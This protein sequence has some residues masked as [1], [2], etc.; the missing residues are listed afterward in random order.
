MPPFGPGTSCSMDVKRC[1]SGPFL[2]TAG[3]TPSLSR[4]DAEGGPENGGGR[5]PEW[6]WAG[7]REIVWAGGNE[8][9]GGPRS[10]GRIRNGGGVKPE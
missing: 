10:G 1:S 3:M 5:K 6:H 8:D 2:K 4:N 9:E 7:S